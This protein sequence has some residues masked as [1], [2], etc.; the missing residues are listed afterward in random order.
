MFYL[1]RDLVGVLGIVGRLRS[2]GPEIQRLVPQRPQLLDQP[3]LELISSVVG[4]NG[5][6][7]GHS[8][9]NV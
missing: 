1:G 9:S 6:D 5:N 7:F 2:I 8:D 3:L 4:A